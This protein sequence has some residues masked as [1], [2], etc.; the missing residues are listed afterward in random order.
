MK[1][2][3]FLVDGPAVVSFSGGR[4]SAYLL[5]R[6]LERGLRP[7]VHVVFCNTGMEDDRTLDFVEA[8]G[9]RFG[10]E[11]VWLEYERK[12]LPK[13]KSADVETAARRIREF[14]KLEF[15]EASR[16]GGLTS[17]TAKEAGYRRV[18]R[19]SAST[20]R[21]AGHAKHPFTNFVA[22]NGV[23]NGALRSCTTEMKI[24]VIK[25][26][27]LAMGYDEWTNVVGI[28]ADEPL[29]AARLRKPPPERWDHA[30]PLADAG[31]TEDDVLAFWRAMPFDLD[32]ERHPE[33]GTYEGNCMLCHLKGEAKK[34]HVARKNPAALRF[35]MQ[36]EMASGSFFRPSL[37][38]REIRRLAVLE[39]DR[40]GERKEDDLGDCFC[41]D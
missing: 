6:V 15:S 39:N 16:S 10:V 13:Y 28:R 30:V 18:S 37:P 8:C 35:W 23:P 1:S 25:K 19:I 22:M 26:Y 21:D 7:D 12:L 40:R 20:W 33:L 5:H 29:R 9:E 36:I 3:P 14:F 31:V 34:V 32:L 27:M 11:I 2:D 41:T 17:E 24:R 38:Y 4:T